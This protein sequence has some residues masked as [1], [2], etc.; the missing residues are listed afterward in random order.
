[1]FRGEVI[2]QV[3]LGNLI[4]YHVDLA[5]MTQRALVPRDQT[6]ANGEQIFLRIE[7]GR[8]LGMVPGEDP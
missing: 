1:M 4:D 8:C 6:Y 5:G 2:E 3:F 7:P